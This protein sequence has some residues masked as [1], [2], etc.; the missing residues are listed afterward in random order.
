MMIHFDD[1]AGKSDRILVVAGGTS[2]SKS[3]TSVELFNL[4]AYLSGV[5]GGWESG[6]DLPTGVIDSAM[7]EFEN[8]VIVVGGFDFLGDKFLYKLTPASAKWERLPQQLKYSYG[9]KR[10]AF[11]IP[12]EFV[13]CA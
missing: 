12:D 6:P 2:A 5:A 9:G 10:M 11:L 13:T 7:I 3:L 1:D 4:D 8:G